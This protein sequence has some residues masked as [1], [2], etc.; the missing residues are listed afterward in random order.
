MGTYTYMGLSYYYEGIVS[1]DGALWIM[2]SY[3]GPNNYLIGI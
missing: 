2:E 3:A 1:D